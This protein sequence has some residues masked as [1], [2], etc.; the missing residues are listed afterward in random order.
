MPSSRRSFGCR[1]SYTP[2]SSTISVPTNPQNSSSVCQSRPLR[3]TRGLDRD[4]GADPTLADR[5]QQL[6]KAGAGDA[7][8]GTAQIIV[9]HLH[10]RPTQGTCSISQAVLATSALVIVEHLVACR[11]ANVNEGAAGEMF[12]RDLGH[13]GP[14]R[15]PDRPT[16]SDTTLRRPPPPEELGAT[17]SAW[18]GVRA[19]ATSAVPPRRTDPS[20]RV[21]LSAWPAPLQRGKSPAYEAMSASTSARRSPSF[22]IG[23]RGRATSW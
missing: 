16:G 4:D 15:R 6:L 14:P 11:L 7:G 23:S 17:A 12:S 1:G 5:R 2:S 18:S 22:S 19:E 9:N 3:A 8:T 10:G 13:H 21:A 20:D